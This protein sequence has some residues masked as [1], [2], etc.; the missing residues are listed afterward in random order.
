MTRMVC[1]LMLILSGAGAVPVFAQS[2][3]APSAGPVGSVGQLRTKVKSGDTI[4]VRDMNG[5]ETKGILWEASESS[6]RLLVKGQIR[7]IPAGDVRQVARRG[8]TLRNG[9]LIGAAFGAIA[10]GASVVGECSNLG[11]CLAPT[12]TF[13]LISGGF[14]GAIGAG[15]D[16]LIPGRTVVY[17][18]TPQRA[19]RLAPLLSSHQVGARLSVGF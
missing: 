13:A 11:E 7:E 4:F 18:V 6:I 5:G 8:D 14:F 17:Q 10:M 16:A 19:V 12:V 3:S 15:I 9:F 1:G 2:S